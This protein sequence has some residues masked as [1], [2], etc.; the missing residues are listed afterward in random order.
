MTALLEMPQLSGGRRRARALLESAAI[1]DDLSDHTVELDCRQLLSGTR[2][3]A[4]EMV[5]A[6]LVERRARKLVAVNVDEDF[7]ASLKY[8]AS[9]HGVADLLEVRPTA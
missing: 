4:L 6:V 3:F 2:S 7:A 8:A 5:E 9:V 1:P